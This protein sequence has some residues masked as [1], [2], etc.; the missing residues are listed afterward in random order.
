[1]LPKFLVVFL[2]SELLRGVLLVLIV[3]ARVINI[4][5]ADAF[6]VPFRDQLDEFVL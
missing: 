2:Q 4:A 6:R 3:E 1:M 5:L